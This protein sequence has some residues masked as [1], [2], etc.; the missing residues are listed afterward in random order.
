MR[1]TIAVT[2]GGETRHHFGLASEGIRGYEGGHEEGEQ[3]R[4]LGIS[5]WCGIERMPIL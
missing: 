3:T 1:G 5:L 4:N 2:A